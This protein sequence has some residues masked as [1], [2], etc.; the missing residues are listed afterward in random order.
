MKVLL[1]NK[2]LYP[3]GGDAI[4]TLNTG[5]LLLSNGHEV[6][7][8]GMDH[9]SNPDYPHKE[10]FVTHVDLNNPGSFRCR[11]NITTNILYSF[12]A[13]DKIE[14]LVRLEKPDI[15]HLNNFAHQIS[16]SILD[17]FRKHKIPTVMT[18]H[19]YKLVCPSYTMLSD[20]KQCERCKRGR[21]YWCF[22]KKCT[23]QSRFKSLAN[24]IEM[25]LHHKVLHIYDTIDIFIAPSKFLKGKVAEMGLAGDI[26][27]LPNFVDVE[28]YQPDYHFE[29]RAVCYFGRLSLEKGLLTL[30]NAT[31]GLGLKLV[32]IGDG[33][34]MKHLKD[35]VRG[36]GISN[37]FLLGHKSGE[38]LRS[39][40]KQSMA[41]VLPSE[42]YEN[43]PRAILEA[44]ALGRP[45]VGARIGG[46]PELVID[47]ENGFTFESGNSGDLREKLLRLTADTD[48]VV[49]MGKKAREFA[50]RNFNP[51]SYYNRLMDIYK[52]ALNKH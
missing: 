26:V 38:E 1:V 25:Y 13:R 47:G 29:D 4:C 8:W 44:F 22:L 45:V 24:T 34:L 41:V 40:I 42:W 14:R 27:H 46:I 39:Y 36:R 21:F 9:P 5:E 20:G 32:I 18:M 23:K 11:I 49:Q 35:E 16:P 12:E 7:Y 28:M 50:V 2:F 31:A 6:I 43:N 15:V 30:I 33:P 52:M 10:F 3:K 48:C 17:I 51:T 19:D 37:V